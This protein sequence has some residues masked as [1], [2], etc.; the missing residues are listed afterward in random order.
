MHLIDL[1]HWLL[2]PLPLH[3]ALLRTHFWDTPVDDNAALLLGE[4]DARTRAVGDAAR[5]LDGVEEPVLARGLLP[6]REVPRRRASCAP[7]ARR[8]CGSIAMKPELGPPDV[9]EIDYPRRGPVVGGGVGATSARR[10]PRAT[11]TLL[12]GLADARYA[13]QTRRGRLRGGRVR[14][15]ARAVG[16]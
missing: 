8:S 3:S 1:A 7:T 4:A 5:Q 10:S 11:P 2:G 15:H 16:A 6:H 9:E 12:G 14:R 13:W